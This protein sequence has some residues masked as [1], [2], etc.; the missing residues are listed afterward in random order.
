[1]VKEALTRA[2]QE[3]TDP[4]GG[5]EVWFSRFMEDLKA[6]TAP[7]DQV[8]DL[9][10]PALY[11]KFE[12]TYRCHVRGLERNSI[13]ADLAEAP[14]SLEAAERALVVAEAEVHLRVKMLKIQGVGWVPYAE[15]TAEHHRARAAWC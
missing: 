5:F 13:F 11:A 4:R 14:P 3:A 9:L 10:R 7:W 1:T 12:S 15:T 2:A 6:S 8:E